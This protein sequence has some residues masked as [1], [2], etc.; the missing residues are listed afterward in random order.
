MHAMK[1]SILGVALAAAVA[2]A[3]DGSKQINA[4]DV[5]K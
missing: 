2:T 4:H 1:K 5:K 3:Q